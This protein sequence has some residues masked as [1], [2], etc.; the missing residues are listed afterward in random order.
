LKV[1]RV[2]NSAWQSLATPALG[3][4]L[5]LPFLY[6]Y[7]VLVGLVEIE[8]RQLMAMAREKL[9]L[10]AEAFQNDLNPETFLENSFHQMNLK[11]DLA[12]PENSVRKF[13]YPTGYDPNLID[14]SFI[15]SAGEFLKQRYDLT[16]SIFIATDCDMQN[17]YS[18]FASNSID[19]PDAQQAFTDAAAMAINL[20]E[21][22]PEN[23]LPHTKSLQA[24]RTNFTQSHR[25]KDFHLHFSAIFRKHISYFANPPLYS[26]NCEKFFSNRF[27][28]QRS[29]NYSYKA[30]KT[31]AN[32]SEGSYGAYYL[33]IQGKEISPSVILKQALARETRPIDR[34]VV[35]HKIQKP[36]FR[37]TDRG[38]YYLS[39]LTSGFYQAII[40]H[41]V[42]K[43]QIEKEFKDF[44]KN[45]SLANFAPQSELISKN[46]KLLPIISFITRLI[47]LLVYALTMLNLTSSHNLRLN[48]NLKL[49]IAV[50]LIV[51]I[52]ILGI[53]V[54]DR[55]IKSTTE[56]SEIIRTQTRMKQRLRFLEQ[57]D[58]EIDLRSAH[59]F[60]QIKKLYSSITNKKIDKIKEIFEE[61]RNNP[62]YDMGVLSLI[63]R[64]D[65][66]GFA[67]ERNLKFSNRSA[68]TEYVGLFKLL[69]ELNL[70]DRRSARIKKLTK[71]QYL[72]G[73]FADAF[74]RVFAS[75]ENL[76]RESQ[77]I[78]DI[79]SVAQIKKC[80]IHLLAT[81]QKPL[82]PFAVAYHALNDTR[83]GNW[84]LEY[85]YRQ[86]FLKFSEPLVNGSIDYG[87]FMRT[88][89]S[90]RKFHWPEQQAGFNE[91]RKLA[92]KAVKLRTSGSSSERQNG[93]IILSSWSFREDSGLVMVSIAKLKG[94]TKDNFF[95]EM[96]PWLLFVYGLLAIIIISNWLSNYFLQ[97]VQLLLQGVKR[98]NAKIYNFKLLIQS[99]DEF[100]D[101]SDSF[102]RM[103]MGLLQREKMRR[104]VSDKLIER[105]GAPSPLSNQHNSVKDIAVLSSDIRS[106]TTITEKYP[107]EEVV[108][109]L[110]DYLTEM[111]KAIVSENGS[112]DKIVGDAIIASFS[113][114]NQKENVLSACKAAFKMKER[115]EQF[116]NKRQN[117]GQFTIENGVG[118]SCGTAVFGFAGGNERRREFVIVGEVVKKS[119]ELESASKFAS[120][121]K[122]VVDTAVKNQLENQFHF[123]KLPLEDSKDDAWEI[124]KE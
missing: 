100:A 69:N 82:E 85:L 6:F 94:E 16:A 107:A 101:L 117:L 29:Y 103:S 86:K 30:K 34:M 95:I 102:N 13:Q 124:F 72:L 46:R 11:F 87:V 76:S 74:W 116:N 66:Q 47:F 49:K 42:K 122:I 4:L 58:S 2:R 79:F 18:Y 35:R 51:F 21:T 60:L 112:I 120:I 81:A 57:L 111:E 59:R 64:N 7:Q 28:N 36:H 89:F 84:Y 40:D 54:T 19:L 61:K 22:E 37:K 91:L 39:N 55:L 108:T 1:F 63:L 121:S 62:A 77:I 115:L 17:K 8:E 26:D 71:E 25:S 67:F 93:Q 45:C 96:V 75:A 88:T 33:I 44:F 41:G 12:F 114:E 80:I 110:N 106:F 65:G 38:L 31:F 24:I 9:L 14:E 99:G 48:L 113:L 10:D 32:G 70:P 56:R 90:L 98:I 5:L 73:S 27:A 52:P 20:N 109:L 15:A 119:E 78:H 50:S 43:P 97:P 3:I 123:Q 105:I 118:I 23:I 92:N 53:F 83:T 68:K 104:F